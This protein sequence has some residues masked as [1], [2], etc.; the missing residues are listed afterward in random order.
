M[1]LKSIQFK[2]L[3]LLRALWDVLPDLKH[4]QTIFR[5]TSNNPSHKEPLP[6]DSGKIGSSSKSGLRDGGKVAFLIP[7]PRLS[8]LSEFN[9]VS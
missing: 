8:S 1:L 7:L 5:W 4:R 2:F 6:L 9:L 3:L